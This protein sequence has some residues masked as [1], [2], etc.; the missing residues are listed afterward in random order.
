MMSKKRH[1]LWLWKA[2]DAGTGQLLDWQCGRRDN[3]TL[4]KMGFFAQP[5]ETVH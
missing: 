1:K 4:T 3:A 2:L 5:L